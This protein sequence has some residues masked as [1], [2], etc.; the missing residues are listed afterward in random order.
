MR[1]GPLMKDMLMT[2][3]EISV[4]LRYSMQIAGL[5]DEGDVN[6][7]KIKHAFLLAQIE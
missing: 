1:H 2:D 7:A 5:E 4:L 3:E 6:K